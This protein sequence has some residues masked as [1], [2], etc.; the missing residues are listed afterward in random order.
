MTI[1]NYQLLVGL[2]KLFAWTSEEYD[3]AASV[4]ESVVEPKANTDGEATIDTEAC[5]IE[6]VRFRDKDKK[7]LYICSNCGELIGPTSWYGYH[8]HG[9]GARLVDSGTL[10]SYMDIFDGEISRENKF[11]L[12]ILRWF[13]ETYVSV[14]Y[15]NERGEEDCENA[16]KWICDDKTI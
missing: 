11:L 3:G 9:C 1:K 15:R 7:G 6:V 5:A 4:M 10:A 16:P 13:Y 14:Y 2:V 12:H 8:C